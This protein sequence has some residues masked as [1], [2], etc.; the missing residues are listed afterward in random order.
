MTKSS[1]T[2][3]DIHKVRDE[4]LCLAAQRAARLLARRFDK[5]FQ[6]LGLTNGQFSLMVALSGTWAPRM[7]DLAQFLAMDPTTLTAAV[8]ALEKRGWV[9][10]QADAADARARRPVLTP[11]G[12]QVVVQALPLWHSEHANVQAGLTQNAADLSLILK[13][14]G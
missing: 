6:P 7:K 12:R 8:K 3:A 14:L 1:L 13:E 11:S 4:C 10:L 5:V 9:T 2:L